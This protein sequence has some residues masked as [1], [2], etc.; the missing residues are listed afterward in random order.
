MFSNRT[1]VIFALLAGAAAAGTPASELTMHIN[2]GDESG[3]VRHRA[4][5]NRRGTADREQA[6][7][8]AA[9]VVHIGRVD[10][11]AVQAPRPPAPAPRPQRQAQPSLADYLLARDRGRQ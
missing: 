7:A 10:V 8:E 9:I 2:A 3:Q 1:A 4:D 6:G 5:D 11:R